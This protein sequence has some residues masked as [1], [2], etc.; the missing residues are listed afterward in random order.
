LLAGL[1]ASAAALAAPDLEREGFLSGPAAG[2]P[3]DLATD[4]ASRH[5]GELGLEPGDLAELLLVDRY[6]TR[7]NGATHLVLRQRLRGVEVWNGDLTATV[8][9]EGRLI[10]VRHRF[11]R[12]LSRAANA[13]EPAISAREAVLLAAAHLGLPT[14]APL[15][16][17]SSPR[18]PARETLFSEAG[19]SREPI[20]VRLQ[21]LATGGGA[22]RLVWS[23]VVRTPDGR[24]WWTLHVDALTGEVLDQ[25]DWIARD[26]YRVFPLPLASPDEGARTLEADPADA[27]A[28]PFA[29][30]D[31]NGLPGGEFTDTQGNNAVAQEDADADDLGGTRPDGGPGRVFDLPLDPDLA[32]ETYQ[33]AAIVNLFYWTNVL[34]DVHYRYG[35]D[36][37]AGN[38]QQSNY[39]SGGL[40]GDPVFADAQDGLDTNNAQ[41]TSAPDGIPG[42]MEM[43]LWEDS[44]LR[45]DSP[46][47]IAGTYAAG[48]A[49]FGR[50]LQ[51]GGFTRETVRALDPAD[52]SG[53]STTDA[54]SP[55]SNASVVAGRIALVDRGTC[56][57]TVKV[58]HCQDAGADGVIVANNVNLPPQIVTMSGVDPSIASPSAFVA[59]A[60]GNSIKAQLG[61]G[62]TA[63][64]LGYARDGSVDSGVVIHEYG[65]GVSTRLT[66]GPSNASCLG[67]AQSAALGEG[68]SDFWALALTAK[69]GD[70]GSDPRGIATHLVGQPPEGAGIRSAPYS[71]DTAIHGLTYGDLPALVGVHAR[72]EIWA[73]ALWR[74]FW[75][76][77]Q[78]HGLDPDPY[79]GGGGNNLAL[80]LV[81]DGLKLQPCSPTYLDAR[82]AVLQADVLDEAGR[83]RC[84]IW[85]A[86]ARRGMGT[87]A[88]DGGSASSTAVVE[89][90]ALP[91]ECALCGDVDDD[92]AVDVI[93]MVV[94]ARALAAVGRMF[95]PEKCNAT[96]ATDPGDLDGDGV[97]NDCD[98][99]DL[100]ALREEL[101]SLS[102][103]IAP[104][105][106]PAVGLEP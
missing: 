100:L 89:S 11:V 43:F 2:D 59:R 27:S 13:R 49:T 53:P 61:A 58:R 91:P 76:L 85:D 71:T 12:G 60:T 103:G 44:T 95:A 23:T 81:M 7:H 1:L 24:H 69:S 102:P 10:G 67:A 56:F 64:P 94:E 98:G 93:D 9:R 48:R 63:T 4:W 39:G 80:Q 5:H 75:N 83:H 97:P 62:V 68:W 52:P 18:G 70:L 3:L 47:A 8:D 57:F 6:A 82:D 96:G 28:S 26:S 17:R 101:A 66:G 99:A 72:G 54:C 41:F 15:E 20:P 55:L 87:A 34:H 30:H 73:A 104:V 46:P 74:L 36:E 21:Y 25:V 38:F 29:W 37:A 77:V 50:A 31:T 14:A 33:S 88:L 86:F 78:P 32:P 45:V 105:C 42:R 90:F 65:H 79:G 106:E 92:E 19:V 16:E 35:F 40:G 84:R 22:A 51:P